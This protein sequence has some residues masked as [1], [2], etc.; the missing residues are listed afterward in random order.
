MSFVVDE[1]GN[2]MY[3]ELI[4]EHLKHFKMLLFEIPLKETSK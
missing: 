4:S 3:T 2:I 1:K